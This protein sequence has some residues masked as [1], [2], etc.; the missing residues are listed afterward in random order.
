MDNREI[1]SKE[2]CWDSTNDLVLGSYVVSS[3]MKKKKNLM[4][5]PSY[6][7]F[8]STKTDDGMNKAM[9]R[10]LCN[11][12]NGGNNIVD[13]RMNFHTSKVKS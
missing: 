9:L 5:F 11:F 13:Q 6:R 2:F 10:K 8:L 1:F 7:L 3:L 12:T 4:I